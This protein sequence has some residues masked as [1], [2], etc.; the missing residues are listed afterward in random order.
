M[1]F[2]IVVDEENLK[3]EFNQQIA[4]KVILSN[5][6]KFNFLGNLLYSLTM[7]AFKLIN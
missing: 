6:V 3:V 7:N 5:D 1:L 4:F 2:F